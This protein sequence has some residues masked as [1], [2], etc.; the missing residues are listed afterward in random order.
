MPP[1]IET[2]TTTTADPAAGTTLLSTT[3]AGNAE[4]SRDATATTPEAK[5]AA[6]E[7]ARVAA[8]AALTP[9][10]KTAKA[11]EKQTTD[12]KALTDAG[13]AKKDGE[14][15]EQF[16]ARASAEKTE[17][18]KAAKAELHGA[19]EAYEI[20]KFTVPEGMEL[21]KDRLAAVTP[22][23]KEL[24]LSQKGAQKLVDFHAGMVQKQT[25]EAQTR[26]DEMQADWKKQTTSDPE[27]GGKELAANAAF[28]RA[29]LKEF[30][31]PELNAAADMLGWGNHPEFLRGWARVGRAISEDK[32]RVGKEAGNADKPVANRM[33]P[34]MN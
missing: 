2:T 21:D 20:D 4:V 34:N 9:E 3:E 25:V 33:F 32:L 19:P 15:D 10:Q 18:D 17:K 22:I 23:F 30:G 8:E 1:E 31:T 26:W 13:F 29:A 14:T 24:D 5:A 11:A 28:A 16:L 27:I 7:A 12:I 6:D